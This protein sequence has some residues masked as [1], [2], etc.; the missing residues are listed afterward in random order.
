MAGFLVGYESKNIYRIYHPDTKEF[1]IS[2]DV[3]FSENQFFNIRH[4]ESEDQ[5]LELDGRA[6]EEN[7]MDGDVQIDKPHETTT[8]ILHDQIVVQ[9]LRRSQEPTPS[10]IPNRHMHRQIARAFKAMLRGNWK[11][12]RNYHEAMEAD[13]AKFVTQFPDLDKDTLQ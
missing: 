8:P 4:V 7:E 2:Q 9:S 11:W 6:A 1:K 5:R 13:E 3:I 10:K 12:P